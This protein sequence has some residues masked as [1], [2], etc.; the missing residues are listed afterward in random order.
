[1]T[2]EEYKQNFTSVNELSKILGTH[3]PKEIM[4][5]ANILEGKY[6]HPIQRR[7]LSIWQRWVCVLDKN[8]KQIDTVLHNGF[9][10]NILKYLNGIELDVTKNPYTK[11]AKLEDERATNPI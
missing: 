2:R 3:S 5:A 11:E 7:Q 1:M 4:K 9:I 8:D 10:I 6:G